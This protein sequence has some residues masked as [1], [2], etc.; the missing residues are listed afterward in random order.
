MDQG[1][2]KI[3]DCRKQTKKIPSKLKK[4]TKKRVKPYKTLN[5][6]DI[7]VLLEYEQA[8]PKLQS[9]TF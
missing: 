2:R 1:I 9:S 3:T 6:G 4:K 7:Q 8:P 5:W